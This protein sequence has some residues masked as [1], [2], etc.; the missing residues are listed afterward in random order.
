MPSNVYST[1][2]EGNKITGKPVLIKFRKSLIKIED[3]KNSYLKLEGT[4]EGWAEI[5]LFKKTDGNYIITQAENSCGLACDG[6]VKFWTY[7]TG[8]WL[9]I[10]TQV[11][12]K[13]SAATAAKTFNLKKPTSEEAADENGFSFYYLLPRV[14]KTLKVECN[15]CTQSGADDLVFI[16]NLIG[17]ARDLCKNR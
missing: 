10:T 2:I 12:P 8:K 5:A 11:F 15:Q 17:M 1:D 14:G 16:G 3:I 13:I 4:W 7:K 6:F 9:E